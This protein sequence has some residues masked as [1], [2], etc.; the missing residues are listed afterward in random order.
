MKLM[1][2]KKRVEPARNYT[3]YWW[4]DEHTRRIHE[5]SF[6]TREDAEKRVAFCKQ[7]DDELNA[8]YP[9]FAKIRGSGTYEITFEG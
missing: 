6:A 5:G 1:N 8:V 2:A 7:V 9:E 3:V 4:N